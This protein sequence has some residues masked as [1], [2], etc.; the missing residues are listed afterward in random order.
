M[1]INLTWTN[2]NIG[3]VVTNI[4]RG[5]AELDRKNLGTPLVTLN[6]GETTYKDT[7]VTLGVTYYYV[8]EFVSGGTKVTTRNFPLVAQYVR[9]HGNPTVVLGSDAYG[10][11]DYVSLGRISSLLTQ[12][13]MPTT[14]I[15]DGTLPQGVK[16]TYNGKV[17]VATQLTVSS[18]AANYQALSPLLN[19][20]DG[21]QVTI[22]GFKYLVR[23]PKGM[24]A[25]WDNASR[26]TTAMDWDTDFI[27]LCLSQYN[28]MT[29]YD[30]ETLGKLNSFSKS[31]AIAFRETNGGY[32]C[33]RNPATSV[34]AWPS[35]SNGSAGTVF[36]LFELVE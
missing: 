21:I 2:A 14:G 18:I 1:F 10:F 12:L 7:S 29:P 6:N 22:D 11:M 5:T 25:S 17:V 23:I 30:A 27:K 3:S 35:L 19:N 36:L 26:P 16:F 4:Y 8:I 13:G 24:P 31:V 33:T 20:S 28:A 32:I 34:P 9:G 15:T